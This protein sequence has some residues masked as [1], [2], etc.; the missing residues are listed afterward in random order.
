MGRKAQLTPE[1]KA[2]IL[3]LIVEALKKE[4]ETRKKEIAKRKVENTRLLLH[5]YRSLTSASAADP[6]GED[7]YDVLEEILSGQT[8]EDG[9][10]YDSIMQS[11]ARTKLVLDHVDKALT[12]YKEYCFRSKK[13]EEKR[14]FRVIEALYVTQI[15]LSQ[16][17]V[18]AKEN[19]DI[20]TVYK[21]AREAVRRLAPRIF[22]V[23]GLI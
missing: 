19:I 8:P 13:E 3:V 11:A 15:P 2:E 23:D 5:N 18:S 12:D 4:K 6:S 14:R 17:E 20:S 16:E 9:I 1:M 10:Y 21:D 7:L 22:G